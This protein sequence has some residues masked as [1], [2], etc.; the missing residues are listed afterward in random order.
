MFISSEL[1][2]KIK[3]L[4]NEFI[5]SLENLEITHVPT[6]SDVEG[7][8]PAILAFWKFEKN[9]RVIIPPIKREI[10]DEFRKLL[11]VVKNEVSQ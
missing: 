8:G 10:E 9:V 11:G 6:P 5:E 7:P 1:C 2:G 4:T 3:V